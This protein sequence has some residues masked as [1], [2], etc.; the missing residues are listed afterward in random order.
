MASRKWA[1]RTVLVLLLGF[2]IAQM[3]LTVSDWHLRDMGAYWEAG[4]R[5]RIGAP[6]YPPLDD[7]ESSTT[8]RYAPWFAWLW[9]PITLL[10]RELVS[11]LWS[12]ILLAASSIALLPAIRARA[13]IVV[14]LF[15]PILFGI[16]AIGNAH[17]LI[18]AALVHGVERRSGP[19]WIAVAASLKVVPMLFVL[20]Y[21]GRRQWRRVLVALAVTVALVVPMALYDLSNYP[22]GSGA[23]GGLIT[24]P[25]LYTLAVAVGMI[26]TVRLARRNTGWLA[27]AATVVVATPR[28]FVYDISYVLVGLASPRAS[29]QRDRT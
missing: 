15:T 17:P 16:S 4:E 7:P 22:A 10:P 21:L 9:A 18:I 5:L 3:I 12:V 6:L 20:V 19:V 26:F 25:P 2:G 14:I 29:D 28:L 27:S 8:Y 23:A 11:V 24:V 1:K 13:W